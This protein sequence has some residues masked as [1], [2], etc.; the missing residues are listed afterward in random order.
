MPLN[1]FLFNKR[2]FLT[3]MDRDE[4]TIDLFRSVLRI[5]STSHAGP[6]SGSYE[7]IVSV[8]REAATQRGFET[9]IH[10]NVENKPILLCTVRGTHPELKSLLLNSHYDV[11]PAEDE[12]WTMGNPWDATRTNDG[13]IIG[14]GVCV[15]VWGGAT[16]EIVCVLGFF[17]LSVFCFFF[18]SSLFLLF[19]TT[20]AYDASI[21]G[22]QDMKC[23]C[24][25]HLEALYRAVQRGPL[26]RSVHITMVPDEEIGGR[27]GLG[28]FLETETFK[29][30]NVGCALDEGLANPNPGEIT[31]FV[32]R[33]FFPTSFE[34]PFLDTSSSSSSSFSSSLVW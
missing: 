18:S 12:K 30:L 2:V 11:V 4:L 32:R 24:V 28:D 8:L 6:S 1:D 33:L 15:Y 31:V 19:S 22:T 3:T 13:W 10:Y 21:I 27:D 20:L 23:V 17:F 9:S 5:P 16:K 29:N 26:K 7:R 34:R 25:Q 14:R